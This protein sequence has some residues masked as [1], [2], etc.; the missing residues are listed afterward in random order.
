MIARQIFVRGE[1][2][3]NSPPTT[4]GRSKKGSNDAHALL[5]VND[6]H[7]FANTDRFAQV[8]ACQPLSVSL[9]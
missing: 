2:I 3:L 9:D 7:L 6:G 1:V 5:S 4:P 8:N